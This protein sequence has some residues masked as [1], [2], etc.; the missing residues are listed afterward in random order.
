[1][2]T[3]IRK[4]NKME[5]ETTFT[6]QIEENRAGQT[7]ARGNSFHDFIKQKIAKLLKLILMFVLLLIA[8]VI[9]YTYINSNESTTTSTTPTPTASTAKTTE[10][11]WNQLPK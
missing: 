2:T 6:I 4:L 1:M 11:N 9:L 5:I 7:I 10:S 3:K 8:L